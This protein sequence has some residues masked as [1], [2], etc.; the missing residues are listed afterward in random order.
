MLESV[1]KIVDVV[2]YKRRISWES[3]DEWVNPFIHYDKKWSNW[4]IFHHEPFKRQFRKMVKHTHTIRGLTAYELCECVFDHFLGL[5][6]K[7]LSMKEL[8]SNLEA[9]IL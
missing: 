5:A 3:G 8:N 2:F 9:A 4:A 6:F 1:V 7:W